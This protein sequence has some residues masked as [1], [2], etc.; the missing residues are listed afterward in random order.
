MH[1][2]EEEEV[3]SATAVH[4]IGVEIEPVMT[5]RDPAKAGER[6]AL[7]ERDRD[8]SHP[9]SDASERRVEVPGL[10]GKRAVHRV[11]DRGRDRGPERGR[12]R[13]R[14]VVDQ[15]ELSGAL[16]AGER[17]RE[18]DPGVPDHLRRRGREDARELRFRP[19]AA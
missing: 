8:E 10:A 12:D 1:T 7:A 11:H 15:V 4:G 9:R 2:P 19:R 3:V 16:V 13:P 17:M 5:V 6:R 18:L 14:M